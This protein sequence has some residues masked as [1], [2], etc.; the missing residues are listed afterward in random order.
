[1]AKHDT[2]GLDIR[3]EHASEVVGMQDSASDAVRKKKDSSI[4][5]HGRRHVCSQ[6]YSRH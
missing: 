4:C 1:L 2:Q 3:I 6:T 5:D